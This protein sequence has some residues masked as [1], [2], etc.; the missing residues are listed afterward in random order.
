MWWGVWLVGVDASAP[1]WTIA[2]PLAITGL[3]VFISI[4]MLDKRMAERREGWDA[5]LQKTRALLPLPPRAS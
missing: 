2:G 1:L 4:P 3:F 5:H